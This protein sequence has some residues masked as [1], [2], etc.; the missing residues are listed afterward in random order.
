MAHVLIAT[1]VCD[2]LDL[3][4]L[5]GE[6]ERCLPCNHVLCDVLQCLVTTQAE[7]NAP[8]RPSRPQ[9]AGRSAGGGRGGYQVRVLQMAGLMLS[10]AGPH[11][12]GLRYAEMYQIVDVLEG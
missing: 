12:D 1:W 3:P 11:A 9:T 10:T 6:P 4:P 7:A 5:R 8:S 2:L